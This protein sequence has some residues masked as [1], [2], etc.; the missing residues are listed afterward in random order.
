MSAKKILMI[1]GDYVEDYEAMVPFQALAMVGHIV[2]A[3]CPG[4]KARDTVRTAVHYMD[5]AQ[6]FR[7]D[8]GHDFTLNA[9]FYEIDEADYDGLLIPGGRAPEYIRRDPRVVEMVQHFAREGKP[10]AA[11]CHGLQVLIAADLCRGRR[12]TGF[13]TIDCDLKHAGADFVDRGLDGTVVDGNL[14]SGASW[15]SHP[16]WL[17]RFLEMLGTKVAL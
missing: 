3:V 9:T 10:I 17:A 1:V 7:E 5:G 6:T 4:K 11:L 15:L 14:V 8:R 2:H 16:T 13:P 12:L